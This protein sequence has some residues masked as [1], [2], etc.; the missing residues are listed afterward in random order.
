VSAEGAAAEVEASLDK[1]ATSYRDSF[2]KI[3]CS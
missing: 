1:L 2:G 3:D